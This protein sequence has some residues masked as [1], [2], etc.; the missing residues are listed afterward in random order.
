M[1]G[2][3][4]VN[5]QVYLDNSATTRPSER[6]VLA[7]E[8][9]LREG[10][11]NPSSLYKPAMEAQKRVDACRQKLGQGRRVI[12]T[13]SGTEADNLAI[14]GRAM[15]YKKPGR[16]LYLAVEHPAVVKACLGAERLGHQAQAIPVT[17]EG[18]AD[19]NVLESM[20]GPDVLLLCVMQVNNETGA[21]QPISQIAALRDRLAPDAAIHVDG[22]QG[23]LRVPFEWT[24]IQSYA[25]SAH[26]I[27]GPKGVGALVTA[28][29]YRLSPLLLG[30]GQEGGMRSGTENT[31]GIAGFLAAIEDYPLDANGTMRALKRRLYEKIL[32]AVPGAR[33]NGPAIDADE[34]APHILNISVPPVRSDT[35]LYALEGSGILV[36]SGS[37]CSS[38]KQRLSQTLKAMRVPASDAECALRFSLCRDNTPDEIDYTVRELQRHYQTL[39]RFTRR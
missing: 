13:G 36:S 2:I 16:I 30:G 15:L 11:H 38:A 37:A 7:M 20:L 4:G 6:V 24:G 39:S 23:F 10:Y 3:R 27:H 34:S 19:L 8:N 21:V 9:C 18:V 17:P 29:D 22:V 25:V 14:L 5:M 12:F 32:D 33:L 26:K 28:K 35:M 1:A 31:V